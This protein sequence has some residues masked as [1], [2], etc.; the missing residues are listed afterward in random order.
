MVRFGPDI[1]LSDLLI[2][3]WRLETAV[4]ATRRPILFLGRGTIRRWSC[5]VVFGALNTRPPA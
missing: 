4:G 1:A 2:G 3:R 5:L